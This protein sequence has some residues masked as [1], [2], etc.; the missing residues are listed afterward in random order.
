MGKDII[1]TWPD[2]WNAILGNFIL[3]G[4]HAACMH[5]CQDWLPQ[6]WNYLMIV[7]DAH[8]NRMF[9]N[10][11]MTGVN[12]LSPECVPPFKIVC[13]MVVTQAFFHAFL[14]ER[15][16]IFLR[17]IE[18]FLPNPWVFLGFAWVFRDLH[19]VF[20]LEIC[21]VL[22]K[23]IDFLVKLLGFFLCLISILHQKT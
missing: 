7:L 1:I 14:E 17:Y 4:L 11:H 12:A 9:C 13:S 3:T 8:I 19:E 2:Q 20:F 10:H 15:G 16:G 22:Q 18:F 5:T 6:N 21:W 23:L